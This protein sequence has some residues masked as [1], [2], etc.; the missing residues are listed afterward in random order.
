M[1]R[2]EAVNNLSKLELRANST[3]HPIHTIVE[4]V[5]GFFVAELDSDGQLD[6]SIEPRGYLEVKVRSLKSGNVLLDR[7]M[8]GRLD[9]Y[10]Y[11]SIKAEVTLIK[12]TG[13][14][15][16]YLAAGD[17]SFHGVTRRL[18]DKLSIKQLDDRTLEISG[19]TEV[20]TRD[21]RVEPPKLF[22]LKVEP[23]VKVILKFVV[24][25]VG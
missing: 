20:N 15:G 2:F 5:D 23:R 14:T 24:E 9:I 3:V 7:A 22:M 4:E 19:V 25:R 17:I 11:P 8:Q 1:A 6:L 16:V 18:E 12:E 10:R 13:E 21:F